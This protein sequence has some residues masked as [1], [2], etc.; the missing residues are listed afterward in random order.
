[1]L[2]FTGTPLVLPQWG[3]EDRPNEVWPAA[4]FEMFAIK[5]REELETFLFLCYKYCHALGPTP[6]HN[7]PTPSRR[8]T[9][10]QMLAYRSDQEALTNTGEVDVIKEE[11]LQEEQII[12]PVEK[13]VPEAVPPNVTVRGRT[14][15]ANTAI[16]NRGYVNNPA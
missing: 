1:M 2:D 6:D 4:E 10:E 13:A 12:P 15:T 14:T 11:P 16:P 8:Q 3:R 5:Y 7:T 9:K